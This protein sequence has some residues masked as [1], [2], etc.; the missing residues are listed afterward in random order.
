MAIIY[1][2]IPED[3]ERFASHVSIKTRRRGDE[4]QFVWCPY[5]RGGGKDKN[6]FSI[7]LKS[8]QF[9]C[10]RASCSISGNMIILSRDFGFSLGRDSDTYYGIKWQRF[11]TFTKVPENIEIKDAAVRY[12][13]SRGSSQETTKRYYITTEK[14]HDNVLVFPFYDPENQLQFI[15]YRNTTFQKDQGGSKEWCEEN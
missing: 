9:K 13:K 6:T 1:E 11:K 12:M 14:D 2:F 15:K 10:L 3:A 4:L 7:N 5:C 8:G